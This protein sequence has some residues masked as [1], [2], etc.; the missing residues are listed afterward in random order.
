MILMKTD[1]AWRLIIMPWRHHGAASGI[2]PHHV[3]KKNGKDDTSPPVQLTLRAYVG[4]LFK[5]YCSV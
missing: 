1:L 2:I 4:V 5:K 3:T